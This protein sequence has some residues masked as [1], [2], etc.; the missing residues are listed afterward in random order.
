[1][2]EMRDVIIAT[3]LMTRISIC[4]ANR[5]VQRNQLWEKIVALDGEIE[6][7][8]EAIHQLELMPGH[9]VALP[10]RLEEK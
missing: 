8:S 9:N 10:T 2:E 1:M 4:V 3:D 5:R 6:G 7:L